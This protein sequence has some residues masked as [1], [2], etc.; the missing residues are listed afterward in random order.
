MVR[1]YKSK[2]I[3]GAAGQDKPV[4]TA[5]NKSR[6]VYFV[7]D[8]FIVGDRLRCLAKVVDF[9]KECLVIKVYRSLLGG[10]VFSVMGRMA[11]LRR[12]ARKATVDSGS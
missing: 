1:R 9:T 10:R 4:P 8:G 5:P 6:S 3:V 7:S 11:E 12:L 2:R